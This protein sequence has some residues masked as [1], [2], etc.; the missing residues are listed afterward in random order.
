[1]KTLTEFFHME[2]FQATWFD[3]TAV[4]KFWI[5]SDLLNTFP[6]TNSILTHGSDKMPSAFHIVLYTPQMRA[7]LKS[8]TSR[9]LVIDFAKKNTNRS[10]YLL[11]LVTGIVHF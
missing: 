7:P 3:I 10:V 9:R 5:V 8:K 2:M 1:M 6:E 4:S 11:I